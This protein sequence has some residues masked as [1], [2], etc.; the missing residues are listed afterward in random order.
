MRID[1]HHHL[2][3]LQVRDQPWTRDLPTLRRSFS[4]EDLRPLM[5]ANGVDGSVLDVPRHFLRADQH[6]L[7][8]GIVDSGEVR[9]A[10]DVQGEAGAREQLYRRVLQ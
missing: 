10:V 7:E 2:W 5:L 3:D 8:L 6:A 4:V 1:A 9:P